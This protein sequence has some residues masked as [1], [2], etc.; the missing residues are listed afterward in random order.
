VTENE[1]D[2]AEGNYHIDKIANLAVMNC[3]ALRLGNN[4]GSYNKF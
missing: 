2:L 3:E 1:A 4:Q